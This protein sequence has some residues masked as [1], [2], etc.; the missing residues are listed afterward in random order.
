MSLA[1]DVVAFFE[2]TQK[3][4]EVALFDPSRT[5]EV[6]GDGEFVGLAARAE[7]VLT[8][9][10]TAVR[11][12][13][14]ALAIHRNRMKPFLVPVT[15]V[16]TWP[17]RSNPNGSE[18]TF[19]VLREMIESARNEIVLL[20]YEVSNP[21]IIALLAQRTRDGI[22]VTMIVDADRT[23]LA[24]LTDQWPQ[25]APAQFYVGSASSLTGKYASVHGKV[26]IVDQC[27]ILVTSANF[28]HH[29][30]EENV[31]FGIRLGGPAA[32]EARAVIEQLIV[33]GVAEPLPPISK[34]A[35]PSPDTHHSRIEGESVPSQTRPEN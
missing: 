29:G 4:F 18:S 14:Q 13:L 9:S 11:L 1:E 16:A 35:L 15:L 12:A 23:R 6:E 21:E 25:D 3:R 17:N 31:E 19:T 24:R 28:T 27:D 26:L 7:N 30:Q 5:R 2:R 22:R 10:A 33:T 20:G 34:L 8:R 32:L